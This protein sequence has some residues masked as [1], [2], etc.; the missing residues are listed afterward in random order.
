MKK[1][2]TLI[3]LLLL[4]LLAWGYGPSGHY[5]CGE[6]AQHNISKKTTKRLEGLLN[7]AE[8]AMV[9]N[10]GDFQKSNPEYRS[11][12]KWHYSN[13]ESGISKAQFMR[14]SM[15]TTSGQNIYRVM[16]LTEYL[17]TNP[18][19]TNSLLMLIHIVEDMHCPMHLA[20]ANDR[21]GN[22]IEIRWFGQKTNL[23]SLWDDRLIDSQKLSYSEYA[24]HLLRTHQKEDTKFNK[25]MIISWAWE[26]YMVTE[27]IYAD[28][29]LVKRHY[30]YIYKYRDIMELQLY[31]AG[32]HLAMILDYIYGK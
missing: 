15:D 29:E 4:P 28:Q 8:I 31:R 21:G 30:D 9:S 1:Q 13:F 27:Q 18:N 32:T 5:I 24:R 26:T 19:D 20:R 3:W 25:S 7:N 2:S 12:S 23:H 16:E 6:V 11:K 17:K 10:W 14:A 22:K